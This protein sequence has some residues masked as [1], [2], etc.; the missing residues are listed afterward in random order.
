MIKSKETCVAIIK[1]TAPWHL[2]LGME[3]L[4]PRQNPRPKEKTTLPSDFFF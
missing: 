3:E 1:R 2:A 4:L